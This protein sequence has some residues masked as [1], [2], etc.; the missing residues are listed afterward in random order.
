MGEILELIKPA[1]ENYSKTVQK[2]II[3]KIEDVNNQCLLMGGTLR[4]RQ[5]LALIISNYFED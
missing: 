2:G 5:V 1:I 3:D 4:S